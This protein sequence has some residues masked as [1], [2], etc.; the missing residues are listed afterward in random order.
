MDDFPVCCASTTQL[1]FGKN[2]GRRYIPVGRHVFRA[3]LK[4]SNH[5]SLN[6]PVIAET[7]A[8]SGH[9]AARESMRSAVGSSQ[10]DYQ[11]EELH[12]VQQ[13]LDQVQQELLRLQNG[14]AGYQPTMENVAPNATE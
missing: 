2:I 7:F 13:Q 5:Q 4:D 8:W 12:K 1:M 9:P 6:P 11:Q 14:S 3:E 10:S